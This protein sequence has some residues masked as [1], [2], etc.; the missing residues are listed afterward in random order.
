MQSLSEATKAWKEKQEAMN[1]AYM[2]WID[3]RLA[4]SAVTT[5]Y[6]RLMA[7]ASEATAKAKYEAAR[8]EAREARMVMDGL[9]HAIAGRN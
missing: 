2:D 4:V 9:K 1:R 8:I 3:R 6:D 7:L 5:A